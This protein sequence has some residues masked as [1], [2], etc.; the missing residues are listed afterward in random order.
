MEQAKSLEKDKGND[1]KQG[2]GLAVKD[3]KK[4]S[5]PLQGRGPKLG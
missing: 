4:V 5:G 1:L 2:K 3:H